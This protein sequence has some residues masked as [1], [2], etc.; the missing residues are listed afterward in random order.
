MEGGGARTVE[1]ARDHQTAHLLHERARH[2][3][4]HDVCVPGH[5]LD[6]YWPSNTG[7]LSC[8]QGRGGQGRG[9][10]AAS[11]SQLAKAC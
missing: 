2:C 1:L 4:L 3:G 11:S 10:G 8:R 5:E 9:E 7:P 6:Y